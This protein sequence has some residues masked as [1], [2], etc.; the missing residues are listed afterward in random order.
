MIVD[1]INRTKTMTSV[2]CDRV[3]HGRKLDDRMGT[4]RCREL[5]RPLDREN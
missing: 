5:F 3:R 2:T 4:D 1:S